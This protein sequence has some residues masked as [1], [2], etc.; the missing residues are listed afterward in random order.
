MSHGHFAQLKHTWCR[1]LLIATLPLACA[2]GVKPEFDD[3][4]DD[5]SETAGAASGGKLGFAGAAAAGA[6]AKAGSSATSG[7]SGSAGAVASPFG[8]T[9][10]TGG[11][12][13]SSGGAN[14]GGASGATGTAGGGGSGGTAGAAGGGAGAGGAGGAGTGTCACPMKLTWADNTNLSWGPGA[15]LDVGGKIYLYT[16]AKPQTWANKDCN[17]TMQLAWCS[18]VG[19]D[20]KFML[21]Q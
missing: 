7:G 17:P 19:A 20:Y 9:A 3:G 16:G 4:G 21:C 13:G 14:S 11:K 12:A 18:D 5:T 10:S 15:C 1:S 6:P 2:V 8:G